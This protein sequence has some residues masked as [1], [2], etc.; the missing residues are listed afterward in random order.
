MLTEVLATLP[1]GDPAER[2]L[3][4]GWGRA[5]GADEAAHSV[6]ERLERGR[7]TVAV[8]SS[9]RHY[10]WMMRREELRAK[11]N[12]FLGGDTIKEVQVKLRKTYGR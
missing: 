7:L 12:G 3:V 5:V 6:V 10:E 9:V 4:E 2:A 11:L 8:D 1:L